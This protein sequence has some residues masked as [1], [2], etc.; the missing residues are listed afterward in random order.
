MYAPPLCTA[1]YTNMKVLKAYE[2]DIFSLKNGM[3]TNETLQWG[4]HNQPDQLT[5]EQTHGLQCSHGLQYSHCL[6][7]RVKKYRNLFIF[8]R[9]SVNFVNIGF[10]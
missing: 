3:C 5:Y 1:P 8:N 9:K 2:R 4:H 7:C 6:Q 10:K